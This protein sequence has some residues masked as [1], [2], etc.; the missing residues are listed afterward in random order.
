MVLLPQMPIR[1]LNFLALTPNALD[2][3]LAAMTVMINL[4]PRKA[5]WVCLA[6]RTGNILH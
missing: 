4:Q 5:S 1:V 6:C 2:G 3:M